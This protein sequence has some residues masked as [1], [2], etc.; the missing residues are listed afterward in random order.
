MSEIVYDLLVVDDQ[1]GVRRLLY[2]AFSDDGLQV[3]MASSG[4]EAVQKVSASRVSLVLLDMKMPGMNGLETLQELRKV[5]AG[6]PVVMMTAY[7]ELDLMAEARKLGI[8]HYVTKPFDL[9]EVRYLVKA[10]L[11]ESR[12]RD[13]YV[14]ETG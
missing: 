4:A 13:K 2:E 14:V 10:L 1:A 8:R 3:A 6:L 9:Q 12:P 11:V 5:D 7:G